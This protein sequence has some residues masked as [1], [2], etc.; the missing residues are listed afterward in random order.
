MDEIIK[1]FHET[2]SWRIYHKSQGKIGQIEALACVVREKALLDALIVLGLSA[3]ER[4]KL[5]KI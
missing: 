1:L 3:E 4:R 5:E 2:R